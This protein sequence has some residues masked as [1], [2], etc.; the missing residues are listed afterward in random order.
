MKKLTL[1]SLFIV[2]AVCLAT[3]QPGGGPPPDPGQPV[4]LSGVEV[5]VGAG[6]LYGIKNMVAKRKREKR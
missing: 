6:L 3:A 4:P 2:L 5:L 1:S